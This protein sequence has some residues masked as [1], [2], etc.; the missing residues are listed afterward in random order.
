MASGQPDGRGS[1]L[2]DRVVEPDWVTSWR[3]GTGPGAQSLWGSA[4]D[5]QRAALPSGI[6]VLGTKILEECSGGTAW[7]MRQLLVR[8]CQ[9]ISSALPKLPT[10]WGEDRRPKGN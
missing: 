2:E 7:V 8:R 5:E 1:L 6:T 9:G 3:P 10:R 4:V